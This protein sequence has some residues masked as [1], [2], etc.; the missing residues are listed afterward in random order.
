MITQEQR[1]D[2]A[3]HIVWLVDG[4]FGTSGVLRQPAN[5]RAA[6][7]T[8]DEQADELRLLRRIVRRDRE[9]DAWQEWET[10]YGGA[11]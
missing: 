8:I 1:H 2:L 7:A 10:K 4:D 5:I 9:Y 11:K 6:L 3:A